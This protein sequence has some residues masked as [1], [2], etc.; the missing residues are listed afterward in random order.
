MLE[1]HKT[2]ISPASRKY[3]SSSRKTS[4]KTQLTSV[5]TNSTREDMLD[6]RKAPPSLSAHFLKNCF[7]SISSFY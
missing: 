1:S 4:H 7:I 5:N 3:I 2:P 6:L